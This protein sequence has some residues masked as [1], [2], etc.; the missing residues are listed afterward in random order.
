MK[1]TVFNLLSE[2]DSEAVLQIIADNVDVPIVRLTPEAKFELDLGA[3]SLEI[4]E[5]TLA[6]EDHFEI[7][8]SDEQ[9]EKVQTVGDLFEVLSDLLQSRCQQLKPK[10]RIRVTRN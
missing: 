2:K 7:S 8:I 3:D 10:P 5:I 6:L 4:V 1:P 9:A